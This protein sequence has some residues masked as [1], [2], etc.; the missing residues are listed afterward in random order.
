[1]TRRP[2]GYAKTKYPPF[3]VSEQADCYLTESDIGRLVS[4]SAMTSGPVGLLMPMGCL[5]R[6]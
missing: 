5:P 2:Q 4:R 1:M 3:H 6:C